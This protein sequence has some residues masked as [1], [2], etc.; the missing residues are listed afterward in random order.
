MS[1]IIIHIKTSEEFDSL[2][3][4][5]NEKGYY[6]AQPGDLSR[7]M[8]KKFDYGFNLCIRLNDNSNYVYHDRIEYY[9]ERYGSIKILTVEEYFEIYDREFISSRLNKRAIQAIKSIMEKRK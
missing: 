7:Q 3:K 6:K 9:R 8:V 1:D 5:L 4:R 2:I